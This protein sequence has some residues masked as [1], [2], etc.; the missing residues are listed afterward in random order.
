MKMEYPENW[1]VTMPKQQGQFVTIAPEA[2]MTANGVGYGVLLNGVSPR[3][4]Q[5]VSI[6]EVTRQIVKEMEQNDALQPVGEARPIA[7]S[8]I[9]GRSVTLQRFQPT[10]EAMLKSVQF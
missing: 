3:N 5:R 1:Q 4:G 6:D 2:G 9:E 8:G 10:Y 7:V